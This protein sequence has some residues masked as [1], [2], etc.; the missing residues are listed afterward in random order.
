MIIDAHAPLAPSGVAGIVE[1][2]GLPAK[3]FRNLFE[4]AFLLAAQ[5]QDTGAVADDGFGVVLVNGFQLTLGLY[6]D[7]GGDFPAADDADKVLE[8]GY[9]LICELIQQVGDVGFQRATV[10][11]GLVAQDIEHLSVDHGRDE[12][13]R[14]VRVGHDT[15]QG[16]FA[17]PD[18]VQL[19][20]IPLH[21][22]LDFLNVKGGHTSAA[23]NQNA[24]RSFA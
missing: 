6:H 22:L 18:L 15:E 20:L 3:S 13:E 16:R 19:Q 11:Q 14:H 24:F 21:H 7:M 4:G 23:G 17:I 1:V 8:I 5:K 2:D 9:L 10:L 12:I